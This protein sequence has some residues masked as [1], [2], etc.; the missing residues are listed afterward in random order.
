[1]AQQQITAR[2]F[3]NTN[4][5]GEKMDE[6][7]GEPQGWT[8]EDH[9]QMIKTITPATQDEA[10]YSQ[11]DACATSET[12]TFSQGNDDSGFDAADEASPLDFLNTSDDFS[13]P[14]DMEGKDACLA[15]QSTLKP[16]K[17]LPHSTAA[18]AAAAA[19]R[20]AGAVW[21]GVSVVPGKKKKKK[22][23]KQMAAEPIVEQAEQHPLSFAEWNALRAAAI[24]RGKPGAGDLEESQIADTNKKIL[25]NVRESQ[26]RMETLRRQREEQFS[27]TSKQQAVQPV[28]PAEPVFNLRVPE[29]MMAFNK[30]V[31][32]T[33]TPQNGPFHATVPSPSGLEVA[34]YHLG[35]NIFL[36]I[37]RDPASDIQLEIRMWAEEV[38]TDNERIAMTLTPSGL[39]L[40]YDQ[41]RR[42][43]LHKKKAA[44]AAMGIKAQRPVNER[45]AIG[46]EKFLT[47]QNPFWVV[48]IRKW[49]THVA[50]NTLRPGKAG[51]AVR[52]D[53]FERLL[54]LEGEVLRVR[55][56]VMAPDIVHTS[57]RA[58]QRKQ[59]QGS[60]PETT[61]QLFDEQRMDVPAFPGEKRK[62][63][64]LKKLDLSKCQYIK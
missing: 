38:N 47:L 16:A 6:D 18:A 26:K 43:L 39:M 17:Q 2:Y 8:I 52:F 10:S 59:K 5:Q 25:N 33:G 51:V 29:E 55:D 23:L 42:L 4:S 15:A 41:W 56:A 63:P 21:S 45:L 44:A 14:L 36:H 57:P 24:E 61:R 54:N 7:F 28:H 64:V 48:N 49:F 53:E 3:P 32:E 60:R 19:E 37:H 34:C 30:W 62:R 13:P 12:S 27:S 58:K 46:D 20:V 50:S 11:A 35:R 1:M 9:K 22:S 40:T 31:A